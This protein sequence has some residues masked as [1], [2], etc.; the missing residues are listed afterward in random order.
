MA[1]GFVAGKAKAAVDVAGGTDEAF[2]GAGGHGGSGVICGPLEFI[3]TENRDQR[4]E[5]RDQGTENR[6]QRSEIS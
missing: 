1:D 4:S 6:D 5:N 3:G 2:L